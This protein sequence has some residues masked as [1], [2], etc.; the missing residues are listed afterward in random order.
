MNDSEQ[1]K[2]LYDCILQH[3]TLLLNNK[4]FAYSGTADE[5]SLSLFLVDCFLRNIT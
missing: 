3:I 1:G 2:K 4:D 5:E